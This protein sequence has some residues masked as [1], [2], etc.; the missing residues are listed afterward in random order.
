LG[1]DEFS[2][3]WHL[4]ERKCLPHLPHEQCGERRV[5]TRECSEHHTEV[6]GVEKVCLLVELDFF[7]RCVVCPRENN[8]QRALDL[9]TR[10]ERLLTERIKRGFGIKRFANKCR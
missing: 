5:G 1:T 3:Q 7:A 8:T 9:R 6:K 2:H 10:S 4:G